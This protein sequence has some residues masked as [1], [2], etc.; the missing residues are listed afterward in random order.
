MSFSS[1]FHVAFAIQMV[2]IQYTAIFSDAFSRND[3]DFAAFKIYFSLDLIKIE[4]DTAIWQH[5]QLGM[6]YTQCCQLADISAAKHISGPIKISAAEKSTAEFLADL[7]KNGRKVA[8]L[9]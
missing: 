4:D 8:E 6:G 1:N 7:S 9:C 2:E 3:E 5:W